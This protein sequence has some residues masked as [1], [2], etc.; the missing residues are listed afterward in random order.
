MSEQPT[1]FHITNHKAGSQWVAE[2]LKHLSPDRFVRPEVNVGHFFEKAIIPGKIYPTIY[3]TRPQ[4]E[5]TLLGGHTPQFYYPTNGMKNFLASA[6]NRYYFRFR[7]YRFQV[8]VIIRDLRDILVSQYFSFLVSHPVT[9]KRITN[10]REVLSAM[11]KEDG[12]LYLL[13]ERMPLE[14]QIQS[15]WFPAG[16]S[17]EVLVLRFEE[18]LNN[19]YSAFERIFAYCQINVERQKL[20]DIIVQLSFQKS[21]GRQPGQE[22]ISSHLRKGVA[23]D[24]KN[25]F[26]DE[27]KKEFKERFGQLLIDTGYERSLEW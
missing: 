24:W 16:Q 14:A 11:S 18:L 22:D 19:E 27:M 15:S 8:F 1:I 6:F 13:D 26:T 12:F 5:G 4:F 25:H 23:G 7:H 3:V 9:S 10:Y 2:I 21:T 17:H 20:Q